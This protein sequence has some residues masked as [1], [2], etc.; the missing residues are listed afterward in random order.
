VDKEQKRLEQKKDALRKRA[1][2][3]QAI[4]D[5]FVEN[6]YLEI[7]TPYIIPAPAPE[8]Y[9][10]TVRAGNSYLHPS[11]ELCMKRIL[12][13]GYK[14]IFQICKCFRAKERGGLHLPEFTML[15]WYSV[16]TDYMDLM[17]DCENLVSSVSKKINGRLFVPY[18]NRLIDLTPPWERLTVRDAFSLFASI[19]P[20]TAIRQDCFD[21][22]MSFKIE[23]HLG[24]KKPTFLYDYPS[25]C[26]S[27]ARIKS[28]DQTVA[29]RCELFISGIE[30]SNGFSELTDPQEQET[31]FRQETKK[32]QGLGISPYPT[33][34]NFLSALKHMPKAAGMALGIDRLVMIL[35]DKDRIDDI[36][37]FT[38]ESL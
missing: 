26:A 3:I 5:F 36:V 18:R 17:E 38:P 31:R 23:Q 14:K 4:R 28:T 8:A 30:I 16:N 6:D 22:I 33:P 2:I 37:A 10:E 32:M 25:S 24:I 27:L 29:E 12:A 20:E 7:E 15:E 34:K 19:D 1:K 11:P 21:E 13:A 35:T 9:I